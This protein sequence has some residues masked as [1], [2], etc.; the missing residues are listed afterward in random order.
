MSSRSSSSSS[1]DS[2]VSSGRRGNRGGG[3]V[4][5]TVAGSSP[6]VGAANSLPLPPMP[7]SSSPA[8]PRNNATAL[9]ERRWH[10]LPPASDASWKDVF[11]KLTDA[12]SAWSIVAA[13]FGT[14]VLACIVLVYARPQF[15]MGKPKTE[16]D[17]P[18]LSLGKLIACAV[19]LA[20]VVSG[21][22]AYLLYSGQQE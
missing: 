5:T 1:S 22:A 7:L 17:P 18:R 16:G 12:S 8:G 15:L 13:G 10:D 14:L 4:R 21:V 9:P 6:R 11:R 3:R 19:A 2:S 20:A